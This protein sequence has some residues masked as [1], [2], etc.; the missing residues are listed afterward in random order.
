MRVV[1]KTAIKVRRRRDSDQSISQVPPAMYIVTS[2]RIRTLHTSITLASRGTIRGGSFLSAS[3]VAARMR[4][5]FLT[6]AD[7]PSASPLPL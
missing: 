2:M 1:S 5:W 3:I 6:T 4:R 7:I